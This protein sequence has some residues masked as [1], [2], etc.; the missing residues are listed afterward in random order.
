MN[1]LFGTVQESDLKPIKKQVTRIGQGLA[2]VA[3]GLETENQRLAGYMTLA[4]HRLV[5]VTGYCR[6]GTEYVCASGITRNVPTTI[7]RQRGESLSS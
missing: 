2:N 1:G 4:N 6:F 3:R 5:L 7:T